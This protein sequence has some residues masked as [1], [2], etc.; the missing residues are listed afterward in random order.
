LHHLSGGKCK[1]SDN[2]IHYLSAYLHDFGG[3]S[4][5]RLRL[6]TLER[7]TDT[8]EEVD[9][10]TITLE[11]TLGFLKDRCD[12][13]PGKI[14]EGRPTARRIPIAVKISFPGLK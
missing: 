8:L 9:E 11:N 1:D 13:L 12:D 14:Q 3:S 6:A 7:T 2:L 4:K 5:P 10:V